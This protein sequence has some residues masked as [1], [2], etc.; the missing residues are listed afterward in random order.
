MYTIENLNPKWCNEKVQIVSF[1]PTSEFCSECHGTS[2]NARTRDLAPKAN[3]LC[4]RQP[5][6]YTTASKR[7]WHVSWG[8]RISGGVAHPG[9][10]DFGPYLLTWLMAGGEGWH[11]WG[12]GRSRGAWITVCSNT[13]SRHFQR[14]QSKYRLSTGEFYLK[15]FGWICL[16]CRVIWLFRGGECP[17]TVQQTNGQTCD[18]KPRSGNTFRLRKAQEPEHQTDTSVPRFSSTVSHQRQSAASAF[19]MFSFLQARK[20]SA[21][22]CQHV[23]RRRTA[24]GSNDTTQ[25]ILFWSNCQGGESW[26]VL[27]QRSR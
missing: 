3:V 24:W 7:G 12:R 5:S 26:T 27:A 6:P 25:N 2:R 21:R 17:K 23:T 8:W 19:W 14:Q 13:T 20:Y 18:E 15:N 1:L 9:G 11:P 16:D 10:F 4:C 22:C